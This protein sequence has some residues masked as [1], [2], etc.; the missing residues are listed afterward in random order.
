MSLVKPPKTT[1]PNTLAA[2]PSSQYATALSL[3]SGKKDLWGVSSAIT[4][5]SSER[6]EEALNLDAS[7]TT[8]CEDLPA[9]Q[10]FRVLC[11]KDLEVALHVSGEVEEVSRR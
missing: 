2:L 10:D 7:V 11:G 6:G 8:D 4:L 1:I 9:P 3:V 5:L